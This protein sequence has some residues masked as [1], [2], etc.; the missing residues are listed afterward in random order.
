MKT[1]LNRLRTIF[2]TI[3]FGLSTIYIFG[4][5]TN[6]RAYTASSNDLQWV[7][8]PDFM[9][10]GCKISVLQGDPAKG[11]FDIFFK[12]PANYD[13]PNHFHTS[14]ERMVLVSGE[15]HVT[16]RGEDTQVMKEGTYAYGPPEKPH[17]AT[18][19]DGSPCILFIAFEDPLDAFPFKPGQ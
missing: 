6:S 19:Q 16:Y 5:S 3:V 8:C 7:N 12:V 1:R 13:I 10:E 4:Q 15:L 2:L 9:P 18:C 14:P 17:V 11:N